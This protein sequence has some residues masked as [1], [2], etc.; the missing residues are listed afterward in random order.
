M[1]GR[2]AATIACLLLSAGGAIASE[3]PG[4]ADFTCKLSHAATMVDSLRALPPAVARALH[5][6]VGDMAERGGAF[7]PTDVVSPEE[8]A[9]GRRFIRAA[10]AGGK[11]IVWY[12]QGGIAYFKAIVVFEAEAKGALFASGEYQGNW[13]ANMCADT[14]KILDGTLHAR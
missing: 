5:A 12:E 10:H 6:K 8:H 1:S 14:D 3:E 11:W 13:N 7:N 2:A 9:A 4:S